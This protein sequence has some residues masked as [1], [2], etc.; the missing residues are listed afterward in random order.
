MKLKIVELL[1]KCYK[2]YLYF[3]KVEEQILLNKKIMKIIVI[4]YYN[5][6]KQLENVVA[7]LTNFHKRAIK[8]IKRAFEKDD[9]LNNYMR[10]IQRLSDLFDNNKHSLS[11]RSNKFTSYK[12]SNI[13]IM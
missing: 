7:H 13:V 1:V 3:I 2:N 12:I 10:M 6:F 5:L 8:M 11:L 9:I 4:K